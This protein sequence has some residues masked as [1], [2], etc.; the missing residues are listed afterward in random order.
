MKQLTI[1]TPTYNRG[2]TLPRLY[3][4]LI[5][6]DASLF[7]WLIVDDGSTDNTRQLVNSWINE[8]KVGIRYVYQENAG[9]MAAHNRGVKECKTEFFLCCDS[10]DWM[11]SNSVKSILDFW[12]VNQEKLPNLANSMPIQQKELSGMICPKKIENYNFNPLLLLPSDIKRSTLSGL[13]DNGYRGETALVF[14]TSLLR[15]YPFLIIKRE[16]FIPESYI[17]DQLDEKYELLVYHGYWMEC[18]YQEDGYT[19]NGLKLRLKNPKGFLVC[20]IFQLKKKFSIMKA[21]HV[22]ALIE[23]IGEPYPYKKLPHKFRLS[24]LFPLGKLLGIRYKRIA[25]RL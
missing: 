25:T 24:F 3:R 13:Y 10:D 15:K 16:K 9:K 21:L 14:K 20:E 2:Y 4:S 12:N 17:Y 8:K 5:N 11:V 23:Y 1:F 6:Q 22:I 7:E 19:K 18:E